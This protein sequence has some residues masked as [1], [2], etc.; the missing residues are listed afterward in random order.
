M[1]LLLAQVDAEVPREFHMYSWTHLFAVA[2]VLGLTAGLAWLGRRWRGT[3]PGRALLWGWVGFV[4][5]LQVVSII[6]YA[7]WPKF[8][9]GHSLPLEVCDLAGI[10]AALALSL[11]NRTLRTV[12]YYWG[13]GLSTQALVTPIVRT[14]P[15]TFRFYMFW[16]TH[17]AI[18]GSA[19]YVL[20]V[21]GYRPRWRDLGVITLVLL[22]YGAVIIPLDVAFGFDYGFAG[23]AQIGATTIVDFL[24]P[25][26]LRLVFM[27]LIIE[28]VF[29]VLTVVWPQREAACAP[30]STDS[31]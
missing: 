27:F 12:L 23:N 14:G 20:A 10:V 4:A 11:R 13:I 8:A 29:V 16:V 21:E 3:A 18:L 25:W 1:P 7:V 15:T 17:A 28:A 31:R 22:A 6:F 26:P 2:G 24:G 30:P 5:A 19:V 9:W